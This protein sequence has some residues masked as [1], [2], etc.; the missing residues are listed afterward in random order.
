MDLS[1]LYDGDDETEKPPVKL[2][3]LLDV[4]LTRQFIATILCLSYLFY[5]SDSLT[6]STVLNPQPHLEL[7]FSH[8]HKHHTITQ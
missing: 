8:T 6:L 3:W 5:R 2:Q 7:F 1:A 4:V